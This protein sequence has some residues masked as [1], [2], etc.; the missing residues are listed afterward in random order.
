M[1]SMLRNGAKALYLRAEGD[2]GVTSHSTEGR[3]GAAVL[4][5]D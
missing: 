3:P 5:A 1:S 2:A 4:K